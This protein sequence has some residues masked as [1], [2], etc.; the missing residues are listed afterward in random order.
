[1]ERAAVQLLVAARDAGAVQGHAE[2]AVLLDRA[3]AVWRMTKDPATAAPGASITSLFHDATRA[4]TWAGLYPL[5]L[6]LVDRAEASLRPAEN[7]ELALQRAHR[8]MALHHLGRPGAL[9]AVDSALEVLPRDP[10]VE[11]HAI[12]DY[13]T[14]VRTL[15]GRPDQ[16]LVLAEEASAIADRA[17]DPHLIA[18]VAITRAWVISENGDYTAASA[19]LAS[20]RDLAGES[21]DP[22]IHA[23]LML[24]EAV[25]LHGVGRYAEAV[26]ASGS[27]LGGDKLAGL[28]RT[29]GL[30]LLLVM[31]PSLIALGRLEEADAVTAR[32]LARN[33]AAAMAVQFHAYRA[34]L[35]GLRGDDVAAGQEMASA[36]LRAG[37]SPAAPWELALLLQECEHASRQGRPA[38]AV[39][40]VDR[41]LS[42]TRAAPPDRWAV[43]VT[44][45]ELLALPST[46]ALYR[47]A[48]DAQRARIEQAAAR[49]PT[50]APALAAY[51]ATV[52]AL[53]RM[54]AT[55][56]RP[57]RST[58][59]TAG[60]SDALLA[61]RWRRAARLWRD[62]GHRVHEIRCRAAAG[63]AALGTDQEMAQDQLD[64]A[65]KTARDI[66]A[67]GLL[68]EVLT[69]AR[70]AH[71]SLPSQSGSRSDRTTAL[72]AREMEV[73]AMVADGWSNK[74]I[75]TALYISPKTASVHVSNILLKLGVSSRGAAAAVAHRSG[76][77]G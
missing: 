53:T 71:L 10:T 16:A 33:P 50:G 38:D 18:Q 74:Q 19:L 6:D 52:A 9:A 64:R 48:A 12:L 43:L 4:A 20:A 68:G 67:E 75:A 56:G 1:V 37:P 41:A 65:A 60:R 26:E 21:T 5:V 29:L 22:V 25:V 63:R 44:A 47:D 27:A 8:A 28:G 34:Q 59:D 49:L 7:H 61:N 54:E 17:G 32:A 35:A 30:D 24:N 3:L 73:L 42:V 51:A 46:R 11:R 57:A 40:A 31:A 39:A 69:T 2:Q 58:D 23:R 36:R 62:C 15:Q 77:V 45:A 76:L 14:S 13:L 66:G 72:T 55:N 70:A